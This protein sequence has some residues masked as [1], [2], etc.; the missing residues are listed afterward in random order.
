VL[1][2]AAAVLCTFSGSAA[3]QLSPADSFRLSAP[4]ATAPVF[5]ETSL[6]PTAE[7][8]SAQLAAPPPPLGVE[9]L[10]GAPPELELDQPVR[11]AWYFPW[12]LIPLDGW[13]NSAELG[14]N[15]SS[16]NANA[17]SFQTGTRFKRKTEAHLFDMRL[18]HNRTQSNGVEKQNNALLYADY[19]SY[20]PD[21]PA[22]AFV[23]Q[24]VE[25]DR[26][27]AFDVRYNI[28]AGVAYRFIQSEQLNLKGR[29]GSG[30]SREFGGPQD[31]WVAEALFGSDYEHQWNK[32]NKFIMR[33]DFFPEWQNFSHYRIVSD[34]AWEMLWDQK[35]NLSLKLGAI[36]R[37]DSTPGGRQPNDLTYSMLLL[38]KF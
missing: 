36:D 17:F 27:K 23:K 6:A 7:G 37:Y 13:T 12:T 28:N 19:D 25:Y 31:R 21:S 15:G 8:L 26:F 10:V 2:I 9:P 22:S 32:R 3:A 34:A 20:F 4:S 35:G 16:G 11:I 14:I 18:T 1:A 24:G 5:G 33:F 30:T 29:F 38:Y